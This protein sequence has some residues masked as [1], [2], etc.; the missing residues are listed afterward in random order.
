MKPECRL[1]NPG[2]CTAQQYPTCEAGIATCDP[3]DP[4]CLTLDPADPNCTT[5]VNK[6][7]WGA[8]KAKYAESE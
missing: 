1:N 7:T 6:T 3:G 2:H 5:P 4:A 8:V